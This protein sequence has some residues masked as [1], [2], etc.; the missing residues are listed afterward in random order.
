MK[1]LLLA[2]TASVSLLALVACGGPEEN[3]DRSSGP[4]VPSP[5][6]TTENASNQ[7]NTGENPQANTAQQEASIAAAVV[8][9]PEDKIE[10][11]NNAPTSLIDGAEQKI[12]FQDSDSLSHLE[13]TPPPEEVIVGVW[14]LEN[15]EHARIKLENGYLAGVTGCNNFTGKYEVGTQYEIAFSSV[16]VTAMECGPKRMRIEN[17]L[18]KGIR[19]AVLFQVKRNRLVITDEFGGELVFT[20]R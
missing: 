17:E 1:K 10:E 13:Y 19:A 15:F 18:I 7:G 12:V 4:A 8:E 3:N 20:N 5:E 14:V 16:G 6:T 11:V 2:T 9:I